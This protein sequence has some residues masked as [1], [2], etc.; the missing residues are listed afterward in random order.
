VHLTSS[1]VDWCAARAAGIVA[2]VLLMLVIV[3]GITLGRG[4]RSAGPG[5]RVFAGPG[6]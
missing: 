3:L 1:P 6:A 2:Y 5:V 4:E